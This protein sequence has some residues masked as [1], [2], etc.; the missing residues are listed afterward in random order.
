VSSRSM[1]VEQ[2]ST[3]ESVAQDWEA[4]ADR[5]GASPFDRPGWIAAWWNAFGTGDLEVLAVRDGGELAAALPIIRYAGGLS[6]PTNAHTPSFAPAGSTEAIA[7]AWDAAFETRRPYLRARFLAAPDPL[8][9]SA[10]RHGYSVVERIVER[11]PYVRLDS[12]VVPDRMRTRIKRL[13]RRGTLE[14]EVSDG[15]DDLEGRLREAFELEGSG[16]KNE[17]GTAIVSD[18]ATLQFY[19]DVAVWAAARGMLRLAFL[20]LDG[21]AIAADVVLLDGSRTYDLKGGYDPAYRKLSPGLVLQG[22][23]IEWAREQ[24]CSTH[25]LLGDAD[26]WKL[27]WTDQVRPRFEVVAIGGGL[28]GRIACGALARALPLARSAGRSIT[29]RRAARVRARARD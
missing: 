4:L 3:I 23:L 27:E 9:E 12:F 1:V 28:G 11:S 10:E 15:S 26:Q 25:E 17:L 29:R 6:L 5:E 20:R 13:R 18:A 22:L 14:L 19:E 7:T 2:H 24:G 16:W 8:R 21:R